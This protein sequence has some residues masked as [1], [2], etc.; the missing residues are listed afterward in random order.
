MKIDLTFWL[1]IALGAS[2]SINFIAFYY[3]RVVLGRLLDVGENLDDLTKMIASYRNHLKSVYEM[4][5]F[6]GDETL[7]FL[8]QHTRSLHEILEEYEDVYSIIEQQEDD[9]I[10]E[11]ENLDA[12][13]KTNEE[14]VFYAG[15]RTSNN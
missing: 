2:V 11:E 4:E 12:P 5:M 9:E 3:I 13:K 15:T 10:E 14:N 1:I 7:K 6:Y 8:I